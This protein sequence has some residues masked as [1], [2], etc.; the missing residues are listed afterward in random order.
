MTREVSVLVLGIDDVG[1]DPAAKRSYE[2]RRQQV[3]LAR[4]R[5][6]EHADV[7]VGI[8]LLVER[9]DQ[10]W[11]TGGAIAAHDEAARLLK[12]GTGPWEQG[13]QRACVEDSLASKT[14]DSGRHRSDSIESA[15]SLMSGASTR[16]A[17]TDAAVA[18]IV[19]TSS[20]A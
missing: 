12:V 10:N 2:E 1:L 3:R 14:I 4:A 16:T 7:G 6:A 11:R 17:S 5:V 9:V 13:H 19:R 18:V 15:Y 20:R 8:A